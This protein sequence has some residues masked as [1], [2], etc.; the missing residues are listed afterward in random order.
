MPALPGAS[1]HRGR[2]CFALTALLWH[3]LGRGCKITPH[4]PSC[5]LVLSLFRCSLHP[6]FSRFS[7]I[8]LIPDEPFI[9]FVPISKLLKGTTRKETSFTLSAEY[10]NSGAAAATVMLQCLI[11]SSTAEVKNLLAFHLDANFP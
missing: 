2:R 11:T 1:S 3:K 10:Q 6:I 5:V 4:A 7:S 8:L 9:F